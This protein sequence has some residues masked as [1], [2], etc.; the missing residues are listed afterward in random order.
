M[1][2]GSQ[3]KQVKPERVL[4]FL[5]EQSKIMFAL[6][7]AGKSTNLKHP[8]Y[9]DEVDLLR[10]I[11]KPTLWLQCLFLGLTTYKRFVLLLLQ[12]NNVSAVRNLGCKLMILS[13]SSNETRTN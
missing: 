8:L 4:F 9:T 12:E 2:T 5:L 11:L 6:I 1:F 3:E 10:I 7:L 13:D